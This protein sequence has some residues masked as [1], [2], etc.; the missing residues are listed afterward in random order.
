MFGLK[1]SRLQIFTHAQ[2]STSAKTTCYIAYQTINLGL[3]GIV[4]L[5][6]GAYSLCSIKFTFKTVSI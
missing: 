6:L 4:F 2:L 3:N 1:Y 5:G